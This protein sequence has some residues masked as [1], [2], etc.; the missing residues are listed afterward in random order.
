VLL[1]QPA[2]E[3]EIRLDALALVEAGAVARDGRF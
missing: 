2:L 3:R 1:K